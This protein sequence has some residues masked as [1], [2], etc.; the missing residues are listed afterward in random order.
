MLTVLEAQTDTMDGVK[1]VDDPCIDSRKT[2]TGNGFFI[3]FFYRIVAKIFAFF[4]ILTRDIRTAWL[5]IMARTVAI[6]R[7]AVEYSRL[8][9][10]SL[11]GAWRYEI[12]PWFCCL[13][14]PKKSIKCNNDFNLRREKFEKISAV[15]GTIYRKEHYVHARNI[16]VDLQMSLRPTQ[17]CSKITK[18]LMESHF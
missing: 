13:F 11:S 17:L 3:R 14:L 16:D 18:N 9:H 7:P 8:E 2:K 15:F 5:R 1:K 6:T 12:R 4:L 10:Y